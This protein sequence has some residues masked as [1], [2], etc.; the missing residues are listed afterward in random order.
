[1][2]R[3]IPGFYYDE[4]KKKYFKILPNHV[5]P[6]GVKYSKEGLRKEM[7]MEK[8]R[9]RTAEFSQRQRQTRI[10]RSSIMKH[11]LGAAAALIRETGDGMQSRSDIQS[12]VWT[13]GLERK[14]L[15]EELPRA[16]EIT[17]FARDPSTEGIVTGLSGGIDLMGQAQIALRIVSIPRGS[18][19][20]H[21]P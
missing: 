16:K 13:A 12:Q 1:M 21:D 4:E 5:A 3:Q 18:F 19:Q 15:F 6:Q 10:Q 2:Q 20:N 17:A 11:P 8:K 7:E 14:G 9:K